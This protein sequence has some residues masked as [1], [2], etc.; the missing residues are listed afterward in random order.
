MSDSKAG[1]LSPV[2]SETTA[3][4]VE[5][6]DRNGLPS[7]TDDDHRH[8]WRDA[9]KGVLLSKAPAEDAPLEYGG[10][11]VAEEPTRLGFVGVLMKFGRF[12]GPGMIVTV[13]YTDPDSFQTAVEDG[14]DFGYNMLFMVLISL[15]IAIFPQYLCLRMA[16]VTGLNLAQMNHKYMPRWL[17]LIVHAVAEA[18][19]ICR[20]I[21]AVIGTAFAWNLLIP[22]LPL[23]AAC[24]ITTFDTLIIL[25]FLLANRQTPQYSLF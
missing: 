19:C 20:D 9:V 13:A 4:L 15:F 2:V 3:D 10:H 11:R 5:K 21:S 23:D 6:E 16:T 1:N 18:Y 8:R 12:L 7:A 22:Q 25:V 24:V 17:E 14:Q